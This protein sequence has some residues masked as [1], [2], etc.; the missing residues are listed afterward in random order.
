M[1]AKDDLRRTVDIARSVANL[2]KPL[3]LSRR[4][5]SQAVIEQAA[6]AG[7]LN[8]DILADT[9]QARATADYIAR[10]LDCGEHP[11]RARLDR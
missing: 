11:A 10:R 4:V 8:P 5:T 2:V 7:A 6:I 9:E 1:Q 3:S